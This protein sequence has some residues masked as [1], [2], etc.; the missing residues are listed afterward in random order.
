MKST[1]YSV[2]VLPGL[3]ERANTFV[4]ENYPRADLAA[5]LLPRSVAVAR[6]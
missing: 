4:G 5:F 3:A 1:H 2:Q 6:V